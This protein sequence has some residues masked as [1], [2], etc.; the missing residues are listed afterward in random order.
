MEGLLQS[1]FDASCPTIHE[2]VIV[3]QQ[4]FN[5]HRLAFPEVPNTLWEPGIFDPVAPLRLD[6]IL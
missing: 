3:L 6:L 2:S 4:A 5:E 1:R